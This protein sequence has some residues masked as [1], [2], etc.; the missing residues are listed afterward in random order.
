MERN[1]KTY[2]FTIAI[3]EYRR[4]IESLWDTVRDFVKLH[5]D[6]VAP[7]NALHFMVDDI[8]KG[9][10]GDYNLCQ[11]VFFWSGYRLRAKVYVFR[12]FWSTSDSSDI[13][14]FDWQVIAAVG[15]F[16]IADLRFWRS[17]EYNDV[18]NMTIGSTKSLSWHHKRQFFDYLDSTGNFFYERWG[19]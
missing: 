19:E 8:A 12:S 15:N 2:S 16:E 18:R 4:T 11:F 17:K 10:D 7:D 1:N 6:Y 13:Q 5:P 14:A 9:M 3:F